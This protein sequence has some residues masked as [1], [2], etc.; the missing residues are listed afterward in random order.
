[1]IEVRELSLE[2]D[3]FSLEEINL[4]VEEGEHF[5]ILGPTGG[6]KTILLECVAGLRA[7]KRGKIWLKGRDITNLAP[8]ERGIGYVPQDYALFPFLSVEENIVFGLRLRRLPPAEIGRR[9]Q[10]FSQMLGIGHLLRRSPQ[11]LSGGE[12]QRVALARALIID[13]A[14]LLLDEPFSA[15]D[16][17]T[18]AELQLELKRLH[19]RLG[20]TI[21]HV[22]HDFEEAFVLGDRIGV[23]WEGRI[24]Q[25][26][27]PEDVF[28]APCNRQVAQF[29]GIKNIF[30]GQ[31]L[32]LRHDTLYIS[33]QGHT[34]QAY[35]P[36]DPPP[37]T[38]FFCIR[39]EEVM[40]IRPDRPLRANIKEN[41]LSGQIVDQI[42]RGATYTLFFKA[43]GLRL[44]RDYHLEIQIPR[45]AYQRLNLARGKRVTVSLKKSAIHLLAE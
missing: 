23:L 27:T 18:Q 29:L 2:F 41:L 34:I 32:E 24:A 38:V 21:L 17:G 33:W 15:V 31:V 20:L 1:M 16:P 37:S 28:Y 40:I 39:P 19:Q 7:P 35:A 11:N 13:P 5:V 4:K 9:L 42:P 6:G 36:S 22:T 8:E 14:L 44:E 10:R 12:K 26:G 45:H 3:A 25:V 30:A 43:D